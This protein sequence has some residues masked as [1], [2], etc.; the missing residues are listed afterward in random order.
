MTTISV[1]IPTKNRPAGVRKAV[2]SVLESLPEDGE[3]VVV[4]DASDPPANETLSDNADPRLKIIANPGPNGPSA[5]RNFGVAHS[6]GDIIMFLDDDDLLV[7]DYCSRILR[8]VELL[9]EDCKFGFSAAFH[10]EA[11]GSRTL[12]KSKS[13]EGVLGP[14]TELN[15]RLAGLGMGFWI[16]A[17]AFK[18]SGGLDPNIAV[19]EDTEFSIRLAACGFRCH[20][21]QTPGVVLIHDPVRSD[22]DQGS[23][24]KTA[25]AR[26]RYQG[27]EYIL[28]KHKKFLCEHT[29]IRR[30]FFGRV[31]KYRVRAGEA[32]GWLS[33]CRKH[34]PMTEAVVLGAIG[35]LW[36]G[37]GLVVK[38]VSGISN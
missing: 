24:T 13:P 35:S 23:I 29:R 20:C 14:E 10:L 32:K 38:R 3:L 28:G 27:F 19:N 16:T 36:L 6:S 11:D 7:E 25:D 30:K 21:D 17:D 5:A 37:V 26:T 9:P 34:R 18:V 22:L 31:A 8:L 4:D 15:R 12:H 33:F 1:V 2:A